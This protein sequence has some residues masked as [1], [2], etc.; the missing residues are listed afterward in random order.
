MRSKASAAMDH[1]SNWGIKK[2]NCT[3]FGCG[4]RCSLFF[5]YLLLWYLF[6]PLIHHRQRNPLQMS[7]CLCTRRG[8]FD[9]VS[10]HT[11]QWEL[12]SSPPRHRTFKAN[13]QNAEE[14]SGMVHWTGCDSY[15][16]HSCF[17]TCSKALYES[18]LLS[19]ILSINIYSVERNS[20]HLRIC[21]TYWK[22][23]ATAVLSRALSWKVKSFRLHEFTLL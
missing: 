5:S 18:E 7:V 16:F 11:Q 3:D 1:L 4:H 14:E 10:H 22:A 8:I 13:Y 6:Y 17:Y 12:K 15:L 9:Q 23:S 19:E 2:H 20:S 21:C